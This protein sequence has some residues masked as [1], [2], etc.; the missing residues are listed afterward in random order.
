MR[1]LVEDHRILVTCGTGGVG[2]TT[3]SATIALAAARLGKRAV[4][5][6]I[7]PAKRLKTSLGIHT[8]GDDPTDITE[9]AR[10]AGADIPAGG[11][12]SAIVP[13]TRKTFEQLLD[14][15]APNPAFKKRV[16]NNPIFGLFARDFSGANEYMALQ[17]LLSLC[18]DSRFD[19]VVLDTPPSRNAVAFL[20]APQLLAQFFDEKLIR[21][22]VLPANRFLSTGM[23]QVLRFL[24]KLTGSGFV[25]QLLDLQ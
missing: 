25:H 24:Q 21:W 23:T 9:A 17:R 14:F 5:I 20:E 13:E 2:K 15:L 7:D 16:V 19:L 22:L 18:D 3:L 8:L 1:S 10:A 11:S 4:V 12:L 6:T